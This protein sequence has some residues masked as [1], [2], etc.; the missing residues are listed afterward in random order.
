MRAL[1][2]IEITNF[3]AQVQYAYNARLQSFPRFSRV[4]IHTLLYRQTAAHTW[5]LLSLVFCRA[6][7]KSDDVSLNTFVI[8]NSNKQAVIIGEEKGD[9]YIKYLE[10]WNFLRQ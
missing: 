2:G 7:R 5:I 6:F 9:Y 8:C 4:C 10:K 3:A 1:P